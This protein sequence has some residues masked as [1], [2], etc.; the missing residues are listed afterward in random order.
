MALIPGDSEIGPNSLEM[1]TPETQDFNDYN[2]AEVLIAGIT[3]RSDYQCPIPADAFSSLGPSIVQEVRY[4]QSRATS[5]LLNKDAALE[6]LLQIAG[7]SGAQISDSQISGAPAATPLGSTRDTGS[8]VYS[9]RQVAAANHNPINWAETMTIQ[10]RRSTSLIPHPAAQTVVASSQEVVTRFAGAPW[11]VPSSAIHGN[12]D[13]LG[14]NGW[15]KLLLFAG[16]GAIA[17]GMMQ[18]R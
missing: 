17:L 5:V 14:N 18:E 3:A 4:E 1:F 2:T 13:S 6:T 7:S 15:G 12:C 16:L 8:P 10:G 9:D 11:S